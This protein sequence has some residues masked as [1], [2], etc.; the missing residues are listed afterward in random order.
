[1]L[2][3]QA[4]EAV[5]DHLNLAALPTS[6]GSLLEVAFEI[7]CCGKAA[8]ATIR[9]AAALAWPQIEQ[10]VREQLAALGAREMPHAGAA[11]VE[12]RDQGFEGCFAH[13]LICRLAR[14]VVED[15]HAQGG[16]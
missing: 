14:G 13:V 2:T 9:A 4:A 7:H 8:P 10:Q 16:D 11:I 6:R 3:A 15:V 5:V 1:M 12:I